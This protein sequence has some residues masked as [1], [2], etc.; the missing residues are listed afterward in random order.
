MLK[1]KTI[2]TLI[3]V[4]VLIASLTVVFFLRDWLLVSPFKSV[5]L[6]EVTYASRDPDGNLYVIDHAGERII[7]ADPE[8]RIR[9]R[10]KAGD[11]TFEKAVR[12]GTDG[13]GHVYVQDV[14]IRRGIRLESEAII[15]FDAGDGAFED[16]IFKRS[17]QDEQIRC[18]IIGLFT[19]GDGAS[20][21]LCDA[22]G[23]RLLSLYSDE[24][25]DYPLPGAD[26]LVLNAAFDEE[27][28]TLWYCTFNGRIYRYVDGEQDEL[29]YDNSQHVRENESTPRG[30]AFLDGTLYAPDR[31]LRCL[32]SI[33]TAAGGASFL[34]DELSWEERELPESVNADYVLTSVTENCVKLWDGEQSTDI[35]ELS[36][37]RDLKAMTC[38]LWICLTILILSAVMDVFLFIRF[39]IRKASS[40]MRIVS[41]VILSV[42]ILSAI[43]VGSL[44]PGF[45]EQ[46][47]ESKFEK[48]NLCVALT[49]EQLPI[50]AFL[51][52]DESS[53]FLGEDYLA[54]RQVVDRIFKSGSGT[55]SDLYCT[56]YRV[57]GD[58]DTITITY[59]M[60]ENSMLFPYA[61]EYEG[62]DE[63]AILSSGVGKQYVNRSVEGSY[64][65]VVDPI[66]DENGKPVGLIEVGTDLYSYEAQ[67]RELF[68]NLL[69]DLIA[70]TAVSVMVLIEAIYFIRGQREYR[71]IQEKNPAAGHLTPG[72]LRLIT[73]MVFFFTNL[74]TAIL[75]NHAIKLA[76]RAHIPGISS[77]I[78]AAVPLSAEVVAGAAFS[79]LGA[80][81]IRKLSLRRS[82]LLCAVLFTAGLFLRVIPNY[83]I[84]TLGSVVIGIGW[85]VILLAVNTAIACMPGTQKDVGFAFY[86][87][88]AL[89]GVNSGTVFGGFLLNWI[90]GTALFAVTAAASVGLYF[91]VRL[92]LVRAYEQE[93][94]AEDDEQSSSINLRQFLFTPRILGFFIMLV[95]PVLI[96]SYYLIYL[97]PIIG[98]RWGLSETHVGYAYLLNGLCVMALSS[99][100]TGVFTKL[101]KK[102]TGLVLSAVLYAASFLIVA[103]FRSIPALLASLLILGFSDSFGLPLQTSYY[104]DM[105]ETRRFGEDRALGIYS[106]F[107]NT[108]Q[109]LGP[110]V[111]S[112]ALVVG[113]GKGLMLIA[114]A[115]AALAVAFLLSSIVSGKKQT[116]A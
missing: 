98:T 93:N 15:R 114:G 25:I 20:I 79:I 113:V 27:S 56:F 21:F 17:A 73:F 39:F 9:W 101:H 91:V 26:E 12:L 77:E 83:W 4:F 99:T 109:A 8:G 100:M 110:F 44:L 87:A 42:C 70:I 108:S 30:V 92:Y 24:K 116:E 60:D 61:W 19:S 36:L 11:E 67:N 28:G 84:L 16:C 74:T 102:R 106:L 66:M 103:V 80:G 41:V 64:L 23:I 32:V 111:F 89:N 86:N 94:E 78:L 10:L 40:M 48:A 72:V 33:D 115:I 13:S 112:W 1:R 51:N 82:V 75:P 34:E 59:S 57:L 105:E 3:R 29:V 5:E 45:N 38:L 96:G 6:S 62:S 53:D 107:E 88:A 69:I 54:V 52:L 58:H 68:L 49:L 35:T 76:A 85:G 55:A 22:E 71:E 90:S 65:F 50:D 104:T 81:L 95:V 14:R 43:L 47:L 18:S 2:L 31:G 37:S 7:K 46:L 97:F 63:Q